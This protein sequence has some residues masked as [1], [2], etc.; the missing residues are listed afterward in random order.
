MNDLVL[1]NQFSKG[2]KTQKAKTDNCVIY[3][4]VST[5]EQAD[6]NMSLTTQKRYCEQF[7]QKNGYAILGHFGGTYESA[8]NDE[9]K[10]FNNMLSFVKKS[11][12]K[13]SYIIVYSVDRFSRSG[14]NAIYIAQQLK[15][16][17]V[18]I[19]SV[20]QPTDTTTANGSLQQNIQFIFSEYDNQLRREKCI[21]GMK[22]ALLRG[23]WCQLAPL[24]YERK[25]VEGRKT[26]IVNGEG[27]LLRKAFIWKATEGI[28]NEEARE[29]LQRLGLKMSHQRMSDLFKNPF[30]CGLISHNILEG[31]VVEGT[32]EKLISKEVFLKVN[33]VQNRNPHGYTSTEENDAIQLKRFLRCDKCDRFLRGYIVKAK[34]IW[35]YKCNTVGC[36]CNKNASSLHKQFSELLDGY[37]FKTE[38]LVPLIKK[39]MLATYYKLSEAEVDNKAILEKKYSEIHAKLERLKTRLKNEEISYTLYL[40]FA[41]DFQKERKQIEEELAKPSKGVSNPEK[42]I[43]FA[44]TYSMKL[45]T[46]WSS[47]NYHDQQRLQFLVF[48]EGIFYNRKID[49]CRTEKVNAVF[50]YIVS[51]ER[52]IAEKKS[53]TTPKDLA[54]AALVEPT[55]VEPVSKHDIQKLSTCL[56]PDCLSEDDRTETNQSSS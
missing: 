28:S 8:K 43:D 24:G 1:F 26:W 23:E 36:K 7:A 6:N 37:T 20:T 30:Y 47:A 14:A 11:K 34:G 15:K 49:K 3:T 45:A 10:Q 17:G 12:E 41:G 55:G 38:A 29:R 31:Q 50:S 52:A 22:E 19:F 27:K 33:E 56:F 25:K 46:V 21:T 53:G 2:I 54:C 48:P 51:L 9:R 35:Y 42:C 39:Q 5:K 18:V 16:E 44:I 32:H 4:R 13:I 40:E